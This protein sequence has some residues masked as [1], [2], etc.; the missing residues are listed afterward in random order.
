MLG[1]SRRHFTSQVSGLADMDYWD[2]LSMLQIYSQERRRERYAVIFIW[3]IA[4]QLVKG[5]TLEFSQHQRRG[6]L[7][8]VHHVPSN[9][10][11]A[12]AKAREASLP[13]KGSKLFNLIPKELRDMHGT[14]LQFKAGLDKWLATLPDQPTVNGNQRAAKTNSLLDQVPMHQTIY[15]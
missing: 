7:A 10:P 5:Y 6:R 12:V 8:A 11:P 15:S 1:L 4:Q 2:R 13:V 3:K 14:V 9:L